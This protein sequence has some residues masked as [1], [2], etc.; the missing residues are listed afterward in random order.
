MSR[1]KGGSVCLLSLE[2]QK[3]KQMG[4]LWMKAQG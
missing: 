2:A 1:V 3:G 4:T